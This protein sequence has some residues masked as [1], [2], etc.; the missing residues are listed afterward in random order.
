MQGEL[1]SH[2]GIALEF[3]SLSCICR[4]LPSD[5]PELVL[6]LPLLGESQLMAGFLLVELGADVRLPLKASWLP[7]LQMQV[8]RR[9]DKP[10]VHCHARI[11]PSSSIHA[12]KPG[13]PFLLHIRALLLHSP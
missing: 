2:P 7:S 3:F 10:P 1:V 5:P 8:S 9:Q 4:S 6:L 12:P 11:D 13:A